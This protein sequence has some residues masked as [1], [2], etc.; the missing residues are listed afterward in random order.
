M[1]TII[2]GVG[3]YGVSNKAG[4]G[5][6][7]YALGSCVAL[8]LY[9]PRKKTAGMAHIALPDSSIRKERAASK[10][11]YFADTAITSLIAAMSR[12][13]GDSRR[14]LVAKLAGG[15]NI[16]DAEGTFSIGSRNVAAVNDLLARHGLSPLAQDVG[17]Q[18]SRTVTVNVDTGKVTLSSP[19]RKDW[20]L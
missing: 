5:I 9:D 18:F 13:R 12:L 16:M 7:T 14:G 4:G 20:E 8:I 10:P 17:G 6:K 2:L 3:D 11:G 15:A 19:G 1:D